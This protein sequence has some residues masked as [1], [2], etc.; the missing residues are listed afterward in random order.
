MNLSKHP[1]PKYIYIYGSGH[2]RKQNKCIRSCRPTCKKVRTTNVRRSASQAVLRRMQ[3]L[4]LPCAS[5]NTSL[6]ELRAL[7]H[8]TS[9][10]SV[11]ARRGPTRHCRAARVNGLKT[12]ATVAPTQEGGGVYP[13]QYDRL[14]AGSRLIHARLRVQLPSHTKR[15]RCRKPP[16]SCQVTSATPQSRQAISTAVHRDT[17]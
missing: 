10:W 11:K 3:L 14:I 7:V 5:L 15:F 1:P 4:A 9:A 8:A 13:K 6:T 2:T 16:C 12:T 17:A